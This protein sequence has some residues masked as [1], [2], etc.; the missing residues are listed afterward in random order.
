MKRVPRLLRGFRLSWSPSRRSEPLRDG[1]TPGAGSP[2]YDHPVS[3]A[4]QWLC[5]PPLP[6]SAI[7]SGLQEP[8]PSQCVRARARVHLCVCV[9]SVFFPAFIKVVGEVKGGGGPLRPL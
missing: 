4:E 2:V 6:L 8:S 9:S 1:P 3:L 7:Q 5:R